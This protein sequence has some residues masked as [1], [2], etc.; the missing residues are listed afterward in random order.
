[1]SEW[2][3]E[4]TKRWLRTGAGDRTLHAVAELI[5][6]D[7]DFSSFAEKIA[8]HHDKVQP[9]ILVEI[10]S[11]GWVVVHGTRNARVEI[12]NR[13]PAFTKDEA[14]LVDKITKARLPWSLQ[15]IYGDTRR[16]LG[17]AM[18][19][20]TTAEAELDCQVQLKMIQILESLNETSQEPVRSPVA[21]R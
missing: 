17:T 12:V 3:L 2:T 16:V 1:M 21:S 8:E 19:E 20:P 11:D 15:Q 9:A 4:R 18:F 6:T 13:I 5:A 10:F 14:T 7:P